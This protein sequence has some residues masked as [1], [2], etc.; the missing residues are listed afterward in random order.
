[1]YDETVTKSSHN[2]RSVGRSQADDQPRKD[3]VET[4]GGI[5]APSSDQRRQG[6]TAG[7]PLRVLLAHDDRLELFGLSRALVEG[8]VEVVGE[9]HTPEQVRPL[10]ARTRPDI[11]LIAATLAETDAFA[12]LEALTDG[13]RGAFVLVLQGS[14]DEER[15]RAALSHGAAGLVTTSADPAVIPGL[16]REVRAGNICVPARAESRFACE[17]LTERELA[18]LRG[19]ARGLSNE[20]IGGELWLSRH[21]VKSH[22][23][24]IYAKLDVANRT[25]ATRYALEHRLVDAGETVAV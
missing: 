23:H 3:D 2:R 22:L 1:M 11:V 9:A 24:R 5:G 14:G 18:V 16:L 13:P 6:V 17:L 25:E 12:A 7:S 19:A 15:A 20:A 8:G 21:T 4:E 10:V